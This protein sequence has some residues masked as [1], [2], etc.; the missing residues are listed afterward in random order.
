MV[1]AVCVATCSQL[2]GQM[3]AWVDRDLTQQG[4]G[5]LCLHQTVTA[6][7]GKHAV[8]NLLLS[9]DIDITREPG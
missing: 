6:D 9:G 4:L 5:V 7:R 1:K 3:Q 8:C 2:S